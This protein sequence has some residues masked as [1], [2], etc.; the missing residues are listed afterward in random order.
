MATV[1]SG[2][3]AKLREGGDGLGGE[4]LL[5]RRPRRPNSLEE[6]DS[7]TPGSGL[8]RGTSA[9]G[10][11]TSPACLILQPK[12]SC[13]PTKKTAPKGMAL[14]SKPL[15]TCAQQRTLEKVPCSDVQ[16]TFM[17]AI[18]PPTGREPLLDNKPAQGQKTRTASEKAANFARQWRD[19][20]QHRHSSK[21]LGKT[22]ETEANLKGPTR[23]R[24]QAPLCKPPL[25]L[26]LAEG[27]RRSR[28]HG[29]GTPNRVGKHQTQDDHSSNPLG[30]P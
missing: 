3:E 24:N 6:A 29:L 14:Q 11:R 22:P 2:G 19:Q 25:P 21:P 7:Q 27:L 9:L 20:A 13:K 18:K 16:H 1:R 26:S 17:S 12:D 15:A 30:K 23:F 4:P 8:M 5:E 10:S 28:Q